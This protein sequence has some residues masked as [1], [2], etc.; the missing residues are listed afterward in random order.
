MADLRVLV[1]D[2]DELILRVMQDFFRQRK[3]DCQV[4]PNA[5]VALRLVE[6]RIY[7]VL[8]SDISMPGM[9]GI[10]LVKRVKNLQPHTVCILMSGVGTRRDII[11]ALKSGV[12]DFVDKPIPDL[13][14]FTMMIDRAAEANR[15]VRERDALLENLRRQNSKL[16]FSLLRLHEAFGQLRQQEEALESDLLK[17]QRVQLKFLPKA[18]PSF[19]QL[20]L[21]GYFGPCEQL[22]GDFFGAL[23]LADGRMALY[24]V[25]VAGHGVSAA[26]ITVTFRELMR[27]LQRRSDNEAFLAQPER[28]L[29]YL[30]DA[31]SEEAFDP[32]ILMTMVYA[33]LDP[34]AGQARIASAGHPAP[35]VVSAAGQAELLPVAGPVL[36]GRLPNQFTPVDVQLNEGDAILFYSDGV[37]ETA[38]PTGQDFSTERLRQVLAGFGGRRA[39]D[40]GDGLEKA[41][42][43]HLEGYSPADDMTFIVATRTSGIAEPDGTA[44][45]S[46]RTVL[47]RK[48]QRVRPDSRGRIRAGWRD[49]ICIVRLSGVVTWQLAPTLREIGRQARA[50]GAQEMQID[51][52]ECE[53]MDSTVLGLLFQLANEAQL[54]K[55]GSRVISQLHDMGILDRFSISHD[56]CPTTT[57]DIVLAPNES[58]EACSELIL[59]AHQALMEASASNQQRFKDVVTSLEQ[60][61]RADSGAP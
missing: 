16:E 6:D 17:A 39:R 34:Q 44:A 14:A 25:D 4:A 61:Q 8:L 42:L 58:R 27:A 12:F 55:P 40:I 15:L 28:V 54:R 23:S 7:D 13:A 29:S 49:R 43:A 60:K 35:I 36:G 41:M 51:L 30:N 10:E 37:T 52:S 26:M 9:D 11:S 19:T 32:P 48:L 5:S 47:P 46:V 20:E 50:E 21:F 45:D 31:L 57:R 2:D 38:N 53:A 59:S 24:L 56:P 18:F 3:D 33:V 1:V 22:G